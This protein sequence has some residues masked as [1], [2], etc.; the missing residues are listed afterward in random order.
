MSIARADDLL[1]HPLK[2]ALVPS[3]ATFSGTLEELWDEFIEPNLPEPAA[4]ADIHR[5]LADYVAVPGGV[6]LV[7]RAGDMRRRSDYV[8]SDGPRL[9]A[10]DNAP[11]WWV[12]IALFQGCRITPNAVGHVVETI[13]THLFDV[14]R[15]MPT[16]ASAAGWHI[17]HVF[18]VKDGRTDYRAWQRED[19]VARFIRNIHPCNHGLVPK[20]QWQRWGG[21]ARVLGYFTAQFAHRYGAAWDEFLQLAQADASAVPHPAAPI[22]YSYVRDVI[23]PANERPSVDEPDPASGGSG[24]HVRASYRATRLLFRR[25]IIE[26]LTD[27]EVFQVTTPEG[28]FEMTKAEFA[29]VFANVR[30]SR[31]YRV[32]GVYHYRTTPKV[33]HRFLVTSTPAL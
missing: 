15:A 7:R 22:P 8:T 21:D 18:A 23:R 3:P 16:S 29:R 26:P 30:E 19:A 11:A 33:A 31:S 9:R 20:P 14:A 17:A 1:R 4:V 24:S 6:L 25:D 32:R 27:D 12:H 5:A 13:P 10:T 2:R 28:T